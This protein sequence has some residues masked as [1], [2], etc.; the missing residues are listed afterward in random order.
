MTETTWRDKQAAMPDAI[1]EAVAAW[2]KHEEFSDYYR[3]G[4]AIAAFEEAEKL[5]QQC[6]EPGCTKEAG[7]G[8][9]L[10]DGSGYR[11]TCSDHWDKEV[12]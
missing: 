6:D 10:K 9:P 3:M 2:H 7:I 5:T 4:E 11:R 8:Y 12:V 1:A